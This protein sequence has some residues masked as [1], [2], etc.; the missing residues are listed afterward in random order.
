M[1]TPCNEANMQVVTQKEVQFYD[2]RLTAVRAE[3]GAIYVS[4]TEVCGLLGLGA[5]AQRR[6]IEE[7]DVLGEGLERLT[8][9]TAGGPQ[10][11]YMLRH[12]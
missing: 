8:I 3:D 11:T 7:H 1:L 9:E 6:R 10:S 5:A 2:D 4:I 12:D